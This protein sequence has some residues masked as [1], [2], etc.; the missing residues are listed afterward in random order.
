VNVCR[1]LTYLK[2]LNP[3]SNPI[4]ARGD[5]MKPYFQDDAVT[6]YHLTN[7]LMC[8]NLSLDNCTEVH[9]WM[10]KKEHSDTEQDNVVRIS[11]NLHRAREKVTSKLKNILRNARG[12]GLS[13]TIGRAI[14]LRGFRAVLERKGIT[15]L[16]L[17][18]SV[19]IQKLNGITR[20]TI[21]QI[22]NLIIYS[23][24][25]ENATCNRMVG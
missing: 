3:A 2:T 5:N 22:T 20:T 6:I 18:N 11:L 24:F 12:L 21:Q 17:V 19:V 10:P 23:S 1:I 25:A 9:I 13:I 4:L 16:N 15:K 8:D 7:V 14:Q